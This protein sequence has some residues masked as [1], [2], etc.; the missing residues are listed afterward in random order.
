[1]TGFSLLFSFLLE[2]LF[3]RSSAK[4][5]TQ[6]LAC[7]VTH[8][9]LCTGFIPYIYHIAHDHAH[10]RTHARTQMQVLVL[11]LLFPG[12]RLEIINLFVVAV[13]GHTVRN[14]LFQ[15]TKEFFFY[16]LTWENFRGLSI[17]QVCLFLSVCCLFFSIFNY[18]KFDEI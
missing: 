8:T 6:K 12:K 4:I 7:L 14:S 17:V 16:V 15:F 1:M 10:A 5:S 18:I 13:V 11:L 2:P 9:V 3:H